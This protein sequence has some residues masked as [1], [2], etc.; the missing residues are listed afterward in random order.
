M[1][2]NHYGKRS[3]P[4]ASV[5]IDDFGTEHN[6]VTGDGDFGNVYSATFDQA[7]LFMR[8][9]LQEPEAFADLWDR[10]H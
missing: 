7:A 8:S 1:Q 4:T 3:N 10:R 9:A 2:L 6:L 5:V